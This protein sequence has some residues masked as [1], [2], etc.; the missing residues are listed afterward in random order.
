MALSRALQ[1]LSEK[2]PSGKDD[3]SKARR[4]ALWKRADPNGNGYLSLAEVDLMVRDSV[5]TMMF[6]AKPAI[7]AAFHAARKSGGGKQEGRAGDYVEYKEFRTLFVM[8]RQYYEVRPPH[9]R[10]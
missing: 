10:C 3:D 6:S 5:G 8:L 7:A 1:A 4:K 2:L 9:Q